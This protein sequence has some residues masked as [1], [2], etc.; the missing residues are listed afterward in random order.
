MSWRRIRSLV[1]Q[2]LYMTKRE[3][4]LW[5]DLVFFSLVNVLVFGL[6]ARFLTTENPAAGLYLLSGMLLWEVVRL[7]QYTVTMMSLWNLWS[8]NLSNLFIAPLSLAECAS[9]NMLSATL[10]T[11]AVFL[12]LILATNIV[13]DFNL[14]SGGAAPLALTFI[15]LLIFSSALGLVLLGLVLRFGVRVQALAWSAVFLFQPLIGVYFPITVL[16]GFV[17]AISKMIPATHAFQ[18]MRN[19][20]A[21]TGDVYGPLL[22][23]MAM[24][25]VALVLSYLALAALHRRSM[26]VG[27]FARNG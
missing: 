18:G 15:A 5:I 17:Q 9:A 7:T 14:L 26:V 19:A 25:A 23:S 6:I 22:L 13:F 16:P 21:G 12:P 27:Q 1:L 4:V 3:V 24:G 10:K 20:L 8:R 2:D 11:L